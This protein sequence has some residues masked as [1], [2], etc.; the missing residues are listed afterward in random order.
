M[1]FHGATFSLTLM[2]Y[3]SEKIEII[4]IKFYKLVKIL[5][6]PWLV[7]KQSLVAPVNLWKIEV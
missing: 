5:R 7:K 6:A 2:T 4:I 3:L 1:I